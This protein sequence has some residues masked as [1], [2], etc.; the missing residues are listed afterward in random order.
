MLSLVGLLGATCGRVSSLILFLYHGRTMCVAQAY[1]PFKWVKIGFKYP[2]I[3]R[4][5]RCVGLSLSDSAETET[6]IRDPLELREDWNLKREEN[7]I[8]LF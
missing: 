7:A 8:T 1:L 5:R 3:D 4:V 2:E 6:L